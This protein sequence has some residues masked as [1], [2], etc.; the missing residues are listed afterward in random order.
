MNPILKRDSDAKPIIRG[1][2]RHAL[3]GSYTLIMDTLI[4]ADLRTAFENDDGIK[5]Q[6]QWLEVIY[7]VFCTKKRLTNY[8][9]QIGI[10]FPYYET[11]KIQEADALQLIIDSWLACK[12]LVDLCNPKP[13]SATTAQSLETPPATR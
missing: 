8:Q 7:D 5:H 2:H 1:L 10:N 9:V 3:Q 4:E 12:P 11:A 6:A 13:N